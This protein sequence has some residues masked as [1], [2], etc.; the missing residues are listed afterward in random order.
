[1]VELNTY[2]LV[3]LTTQAWVQLAGSRRTNKA[4][5]AITVNVDV[6]L[7][8][9]ENYQ[10]VSPDALAIQTVTGYIIHAGTY[11]ALVCH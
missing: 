7:T 5:P 9:S 10:G 11:P 4:R 3:S 1:M 8:N 6:Q 2:S